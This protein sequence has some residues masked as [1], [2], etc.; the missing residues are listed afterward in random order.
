MFRKDPCSHEQKNFFIIFYIIYIEH[1]MFCGLSSVQFSHLV[2]SASLRPHGLH[3]GRFPCPSTT[4]RACSDH[5]VSDAIQPSLP[6]LIVPF[7]CLQSFPTS[8]SFLRSQFFS[9]GGQSMG[10]SAW[11]A[12]LPM[13]IVT[14]FPYD[15]LVGSPCSPRDSQ[16]SS[17][18]PQFKGINSSVL[19]VQLSHPYMTT[20][21]TIALTIQILSAK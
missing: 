1:Y 19:V 10:A 16:E 5:G 3:N 9:L 8:G 20:R 12:V 13:N 2:I 6:L 18:T 14:D 21:K 7:S 15:G 17:P 11:A 4:P